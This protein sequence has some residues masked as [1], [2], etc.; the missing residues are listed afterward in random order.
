MSLKTDSQVPTP[1]RAT[2]RPRRPGTSRVARSS[3]FLNRELS[4]IDFDRRVLEL[5]ADTTLPLLER[6]MFCSIA[7]SNLDEFFAVRIAE[8][9]DQEAVGVVRKSPDGRTPAQTLAEA[10]QAIVALQAM[11]DALWHGELRPA[12]AAA[13]IRVCA[14]KDCS[15]RDL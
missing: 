12:L 13:R 11:Q 7:S 6:I 9:T 4:W 3:R 8:L 5:A 2:G 15:P 10:R 1:S 14:P